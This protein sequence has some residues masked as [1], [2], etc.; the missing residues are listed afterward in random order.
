MSILIYSEAYGVTSG[1]V[2]SAATDATK[3]NRLFGTEGSFGQETLGLSQTVAQ[4]VI[5]RVGN[6]GE[7]YE[8]NL[9]ASGI[10]LP[11]KAAGTH[12]GRTLRAPTVPREARFTG[13]LCAKFDSVLL[14]ND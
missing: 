4:D 11:R 2:P 1:N 3:V 8:R 5:R 10:N 13:R 9:G 14:L 7:I 6:Y 12:C